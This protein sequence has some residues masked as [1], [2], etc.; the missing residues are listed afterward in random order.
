[1]DHDMRL[2]RV[3]EFDIAIHL[4]QV[5]SLMMSGSRGLSKS[6]AALSVLSS[7]KTDQLRWRK[8]FY[9]NFTLGLLS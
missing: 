7:D 4:P 3:K 6:L 2:S 1:M 9:A 5:L 8:F